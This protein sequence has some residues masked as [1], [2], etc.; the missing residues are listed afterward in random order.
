MAVLRAPRGQVRARV[1]F[2]AAAAALVATTFGSLIFVLNLHHSLEVGL[3]STADQE[4]SA[5]KAQLANGVSPRQAVITG[6]DDVVVQLVGAGGQVIASDHRATRRTALLTRPGSRTHVRVPGQRD[7]YTIVARSLT[8]ADGVRLVV[9]GRSTE[10]ADRARDVATLLLTFAVPAV[11]AFLALIVWLSVGRALRPVEAMRLE[12]DAITSAHLHR[13][14]AIPSGHDEITRLALTLN[15]MLD[16]IDETHRLQ[17]Q[18]VSDAS[19]ELRS[20]LSSIRQSAEVARGYPDRVPVTRLA[21]DVLTESARL[22]N[23]VEALLLLARLDDTDGVPEAEVSELVDLDDLVL[24]QVDR[25]R[26]SADVHV[27]VSAVSG[28]QVRGNPILLSQ[29]VRNLVD[30][31]VRHARSR[32]WVSVREHPHRVEMTV[33]D[34]GTG[35]APQ[36]RAQ[37]FERF[38]RLDEARAREAGGAGLGLAI[39]RRILDVSGGSVRL[40]DSSMGGAK[41]TVF[42]PVPAEDSRPAEVRLQPQ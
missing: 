17:R 20:P 8:G 2:V 42:L 3:V 40:D 11:V 29:V 35:I 10:Q 28:G 36:D 39:V 15:E 37:V 22:E 9:V 34:D 24:E 31:A 7:N 1:T 32:V 33:E 14:L 26:S 18:F 12:A 23:L 25:V 41:F 13:R 30:N 5:I 27:D 38:V 16:R 21:D 6:P 4:I 19:H